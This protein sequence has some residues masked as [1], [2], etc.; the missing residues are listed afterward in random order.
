MRTV[1][2]FLFP[3]LEE[4]IGDGEK[5]YSDTLIFKICKNNFVRYE[6]ECFTAIKRRNTLLFS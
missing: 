3:S 1:L 5:S 4:E 6:L 2:S